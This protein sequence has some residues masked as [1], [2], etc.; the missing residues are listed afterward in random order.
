MIKAVP[1][2]IAATAPRV[3]TVEQ[4]E[5]VLELA[6][7][8]RNRQQAHPWRGELDREGQA[9]D[10]AHQSGNF[11]HVRLCIEF[12]LRATGAS[13]EQPDGVERAQ[14]IDLRFVRVRRG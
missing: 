9:V 6:A 12:G 2:A 1:N 3:A 10:R 14:R 11:A 8:L 5:R 13:L 7:D 4:V